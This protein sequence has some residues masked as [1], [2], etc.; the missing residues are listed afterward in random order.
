MRQTLDPRSK[1]KVTIQPIQIPIEKRQ[2]LLVY[3]VSDGPKASE[4]DNGKG[5]SEYNKKKS[6]NFFE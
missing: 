1:R 3:Y 6:T 2:Y 5:K 4:Y